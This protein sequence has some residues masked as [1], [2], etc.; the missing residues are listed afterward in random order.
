MAIYKSIVTIPWTL[1]I[2][3]GMISDNVK[4]CGLKRK[5]YLVFFGW[6]QFLS[7]LILFLL[8]SEDPWVNVLLLTIASTSMAFSNV[9]IDAIF[10]V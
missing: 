5:P 8:E 4:L 1:K 10:V 6:L 2:F 3:W 7:M 9:V